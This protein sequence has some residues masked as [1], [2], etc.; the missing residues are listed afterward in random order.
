MN[1]FETTAQVLQF[2]AWMRGDGDLRI[3]N[4][5]HMWLTDA[6]RGVIIAALTLLA[7]HRAALEAQADAEVR[8]D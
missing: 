5:P 7:E 6:R 3:N 2:A 1:C 8:D 4:Q